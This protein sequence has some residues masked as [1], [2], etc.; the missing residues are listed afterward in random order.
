ML[1]IL[2]YTDDQY[3]CTMLCN[4]VTDCINEMKEWFSTNY[5]KLNTDKTK[6]VLFSKPSVFKKL[7][8]NDN[9]FTIAIESGEINEW[10]STSEVK[11]LG[12]QLDPQLTTHKHIMN[13]KQYC[14][15]QLKS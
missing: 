3:L 10:T 5:L 8:L 9:C 2:N 13:V 7:K 4:K 14:I 6:L 11:S 12:V 1:M 15:R